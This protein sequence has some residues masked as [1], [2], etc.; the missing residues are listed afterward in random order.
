MQ[1]LILLGLQSVSAKSDMCMIVVKRSH[2]LQA[3][4]SKHIH[5]IVA[6]NDRYALQYM[7]SQVTPLTTT[8]VLKD[9]HLFLMDG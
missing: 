1:V 3:R 6:S 2:C 4:A 7:S 5:D 9:H 8:H